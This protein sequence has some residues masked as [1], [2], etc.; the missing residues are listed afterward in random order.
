MT[1]NTNTVGG[2]PQSAGEI[3]DE[4][5]FYDAMGMRLVSLLR[6][7]LAISGLLLTETYRD[8]IGQYATAST[9]ILFCYVVYSV[10][11]CGLTFYRQ[12]LLHS[13]W[14]HWIDVAW[15][16]A[17]IASADSD[18][19]F[20]LFFL[21]PIIVSSF[22][23]GTS[24][25]VAVSVAAVASWLLV[26]IIELHSN[27]W[28]A[29]WQI[30]LLR[31][32]TILVL[33]YVIALWAG[34]EALQKR[35]LTLLGELNRLPN[36]RFGPDRIVSDT[37]KRL[38]HFYRADN[39]IAVMSA[40][41]GPCIH[42]AKPI[43]AES[44]LATLPPGL[45]G[46]KLLSLPEHSA[47][48]YNMPTPWTRLTGGHIR[49][50]GARSREQRALIRSCSHV[51]AHDLDAGSWVSVP[52][53]QQGTDLGRLYLLSRHGHFG[54]F[55]I[56]MLRQAMDKF[57]PLVETVKLLDELATEAAEKERRKISL[58]FHD[59]AIQP[60]LGLKL[61]LESL[62][63]K[64]EPGNPLAADLDDLYR[65]TTESIAELRGYVGVLNAKPGSRTISLMDGLQRQV[66]KFREFYGLDI[67]INMLSPL[68]LNDRLVAEVLQMIGESLSNIGR[69]TA[70]R[71]VTINL[72]SR[73]EHFVTQIINHGEENEA[74]WQRFTPVSLTNRAQYLGGSVDVARHPGGGTE[75]MVTI[76]L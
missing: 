71:Q 50:E 44:A 32:V 25:G 55:D 24:E 39:C 13:R 35:R 45:L 60:Y 59:G 1:A 69:H 52:L 75:I 5:P 51:L 58:D 30:V 62:R 9:I 19:V 43:P 42:M 34:F 20:Y 6:V 2:L 23:W 4:H 14:W 33:G 36:P 16:L 15:W 21:Y 37:L 49:V 22:R 67:K 31:A 10:L 40:E 12:R 76:P 18:S 53:Q 46:A 57:T 29:Q 38:C 70:S 56:C 54:A 41:T 48:A 27:A 11:L 3:I 7:A 74:A 65:M 17:A 72:S 61:G 8:S 64:I 47:V 68:P 26:A 63:R 73:E 28:T 66:D